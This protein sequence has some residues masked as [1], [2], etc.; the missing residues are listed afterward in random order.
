[1]ELKA[2][3]AESLKEK[4]QRARS[5]PHAADREAALEERAREMTKT[6]GMEPFQF[7]EEALDNM[8]KFHSFDVPQLSQETPARPALQPHFTVPGPATE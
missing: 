8:S 2:A 6:M 4:D 5:R 3:I 7:I 1:M